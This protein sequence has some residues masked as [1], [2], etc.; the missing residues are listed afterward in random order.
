MP[1]MK[2]DESMKVGVDAS[3]QQHIKVFDLINQLHDAMSVGKG[4]IVLGEI[5]AQ[6]ADYTQYHFSAEEKLFKQYAYPDA[7]NH[8]L[9]HSYLTQKTLE[10]K[11]K[12]ED[13]KTMISVE[14]LNFLKDWWSNH[15][16]KV[17][18]RY[19]LFLNSKGVK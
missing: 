3:D 4:R 13:G 5:L 7:Q 8:I 12:F 2:W 9:L 10:L 1:M 18:K 16:M 17:D 19:G 15:I 11:G 6:L 14:M